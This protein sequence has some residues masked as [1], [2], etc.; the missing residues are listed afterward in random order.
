MTSSVTSAAK[1]AATRAATSASQLS[2]QTKKVAK[3]AS[4]IFDVKNFQEM[5]LHLTKK[6]LILVDYDNTTGKPKQV[7]GSDHW[8]CHRVDHYKK[9]GSKDAVD[10][11][12]TDWYAV[13]CLTEAVPVESTT[14]EYIRQLQARGFM[15]MGLTTR[16]SSL[17][18]PTHQQLESMGID[19]TVTAPPTREVVFL[20]PH[21]VKYRYGVLFTSGTNKGEALDKFFNLVADVF[22]RDRFDQVLFINDKKSN[23]EDVQR[24]VDEWGIPYIGLR[25]GHMDEEVANADFAAADLRLEAMVAA[26]KQDNV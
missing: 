6:T 16:S 12:L 15:V 19:F 24:K 10:H 2:P 7:L 17:S 1:R 11:A 23:L 8:F 14:P 22:P 26:L 5:E 3:C 13:Q 18:L 20:N 21:E 9:Q 25:Y 4:R